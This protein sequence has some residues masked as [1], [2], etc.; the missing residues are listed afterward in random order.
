MYKG[1]PCMGRKSKSNNVWSKKELL[2]ECKLRGVKCSAKDN[3]FGICNF[4]NSI[5]STGVSMRVGSSTMLRSPTVRSPTVRSPTMVRSPIVRSPTKLGYMTRMGT[6]TNAPYMNEYTIDRAI[7]AAEDGD[8]DTLEKLAELNILPDV[9][10]ANE[11][12][13]NG[14]MDVLFWL[15]NYGIYPDVLG[16]NKAA[17]RGRINVLEWLERYGILPDYRGADGAYYRSQNETLK[18]LALRGIYPVNR[19]R[20]PY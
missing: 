4:L 6:S 10:G 7:L 13:K 19:V 5:D 18:W 14:H 2:E 17:K 15:S 8:M 16:A 11:A 1:R 9:V 12:A 3:K 20:K